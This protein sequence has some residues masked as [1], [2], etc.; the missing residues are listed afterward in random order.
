MG[1]TRQLTRSKSSK[2]TWLWTALLVAFRRHRSDHCQGPEL[3]VQG[4]A[5]SVL[6]RRQQ[7]GGTGAGRSCADRPRRRNAGS[8]A[9][10]CELPLTLGHP[11][12]RQHCEAAGLHTSRPHA[13]IAKTMRQRLSCMLACWCLIPG[14]PHVPSS[15]TPLGRISRSCLHAGN[16]CLSLQ[17]H[18]LFVFHPVCPHCCA[19]AV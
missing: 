2:I 19:V 4:C 18:L 13:C 1:A 15:P 12:H 5:I 7:P 9:A 16:A 17:T 3:Q 14:R 6:R 11:A 8:G 10:G